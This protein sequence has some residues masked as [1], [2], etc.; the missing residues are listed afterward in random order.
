MTRVAKDI[1]S[2]FLSNCF[3]EPMSGCWLWTG[4]VESDAKPYGMISHQGRWLRASRVSFKL[5]NGD[6]P[7]GMYACHRCDNPNCVN[8]DHLF[9]GSPADNSADMVSKGRSGF[10]E[11]NTSAKLREQDVV[12]IRTLLANGVSKREIARNFD[13]SPRLVRMIHS[14]R[15]WKSAATSADDP[16]QDNEEQRF[17]TTLGRIHKAIDGYVEALLAREHGGVA[18]DRAFT[19][20]CEALGRTPIQEMDARRRALLSTDET[21]EGG[22]G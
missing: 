21:Q 10:G 6:L 16:V 19:A 14:G 18:Q 8:P 13:I 17:P 7:D 4:A 22:N 12:T 11:K 2:K 3:P 15:V 5:Y 20:I 9:P 1:E